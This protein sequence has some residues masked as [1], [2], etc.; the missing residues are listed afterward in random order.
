MPGWQTTATDHKIEVWRSGFYGVPAAEGDNF[1]EL[2]ANQTAALYQEL[3]ISAGSKVQWS[4]KHRGR[5][6]IDVAQVKIGADLTTATIV[7]TMSDG[8]TSWST[9]TGIYNVPLGQNTTYFIFE[10]VSTASGSNSVGNFL[11]DVVITVLEEP[12]CADTNGDGVENKVDL[13]SDNDGIPDNIEAQSTTGYI[14][15]SG[16]VNT[17]GSYPGLWDN[18]GTG[19]VPVDTDGDGTP[20]YLDADSDDDGIPDIEENGMANTVSGTDTDNDGLD[21][22]FETNGV[23]DATWDV[24]EDIEN[25]TDLSILPDA[26]ADLF[27]GGD[28]DY[29]DSQASTPPSSAVIN[30]DGVDDY[31]EGSAFITDWTGG[32]IMAWVKIEHSDSGDLPDLYSV[33]G[34]ESMRLYI[35]KGRVPV[36]NVTTQAQVTSST[37]YPTNISVNPDPSLGISLENDMWYHVAGVFNSAEQTLKLYLNGEL[38]GVASNSDLNSALITKNYDGSSHVYTQRGFAIGRYPTNTSAAGFGH[39]KGSIDEVRVFN[40]ALTEDQVQQMVYQE[41]EENSGVV[42]GSIIPKDIEDRTL[43]TKVSWSNLQGYY[44]MTNIS[45]A[46]TPDYSSAGHDVTLH[47]ITMAEE[48]TAPM[49]YETTTS[50]DWADSS[51]WLHGDI[52]DITDIDNLK[53]WS[54]VHIKNDTEITGSF[55]GLGLIIDAGSALTVNADHLVY[56]DWYF[57]LNGT[58]DLMGDSQLVQTEYSDLVTSA[59]GKVLRRQEG[60]TSPFWYNYWASPL[61]LLQQQVFQII[62]L[63]PTTVTTRHLS[64]TCLKTDLELILTL[65]QVI[66]LM[67]I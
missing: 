66:Q 37:N 58:L 50:G 7:E 59:D 21:D 55:G 9:Y 29:R 12:S 2:N 31:L 13:D 47:N 23:N 14:V 49:P 41:I 65:H 4:V 3:C 62:M 10:A 40:A 44:P 53:D 6:G 15:P 19:L 63:L 35:A 52:W 46:V 60:V 36:F 57:E 27:F 61:V 64:L 18:Y 28:L 32:T 22:I 45:G 1:V 43:G 20:D 48:Q 42:R 25:P 38:I 51:T 26:D 39:F 30:F 5:N 11:D 24:N 56:N 17:S 67:I 33:A 34:Q 8:N 54:I 16:T